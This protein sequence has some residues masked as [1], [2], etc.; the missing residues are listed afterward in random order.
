ML[1][2]KCEPPTHNKC[3][4]VNKKLFYLNVHPWMSLSRRLYHPCKKQQSMFL[5]QSLDELWIHSKKLSNRQIQ[6]Y[7]L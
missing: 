6:V 5:I 7:F 4:N 2:Q 3:I 1:W